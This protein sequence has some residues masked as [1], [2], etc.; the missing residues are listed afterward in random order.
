MTEE[1]GVGSPG[2]AAGTN[3][4][5]DLRFLPQPLSHADEGEDDQRT[6]VVEEDCG[7]NILFQIVTECNLLASRTGMRGAEHIAQ[8]AG[9]G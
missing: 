4:L 6:L 9:Q 2:E 3:C 5:E 8:G 7:G 1:W